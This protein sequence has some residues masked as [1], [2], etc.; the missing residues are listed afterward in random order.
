MQL[1]NQLKTPSF[2]Q[3]L[4][5][6]I[7][8]IEFLQ[9]ASKQYP[10][11]FSSS[12]LLGQT[13]VFI[14]HPQ[15]L[16]DFFTNDRK[17]FVLPPTK[18]VQPIVGES[19]L[20]TLVG[21][22]HKRQR[23]FLMPP[24]HGE[25]MHSYGEIICN[26]TK[27]I[28]SQ[29]PLNQP[30]SAQTVTLKIALELIL[31]VVFGLHEGEKYQ[32]LQHL[33]ELMFDF[34]QSPL[35]SSF[36]YLPFL[37]RNLGPWS[38]WVKFVRLKQ[39]IDNL[40][41]T[42]IA[43]RRAQQNSDRVDI[44]SLLLEAKD[45]EGQSLTDQELLNELMTLL[46]AGH[47]TTGIA[48]A[49]GLYWTHHK[50]EVGERLRKELDSLGTSKDP[51]SIFRLPY[52]T[53]VCNETLRIYPVSAVTF[54]RV[55]KEPIELLK[56]RLEPGTIVIGGIYLTHHRED[57]YPNPQQFLPERFLERQYSPYEFLPFGGGMR[58]CLGEALAIFEIK[59]ILA[60]I[61]SHYQLKLIDERPEKPLLRGFN[62]APA[63]GVQMMI[64]QERVY[65]GTKQAL[66]KIL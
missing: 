10:D 38:P 44:L 22:H 37:R 35:Y 45:E 13:S 55:V 29:L 23:Q 57:L 7:D 50:P 14:H 20:L 33:L 64:T 3:T 18:V 49:W 5:F 26:L 9:K 6:I 1:P 31:Q 65:Q 62:I 4:Q 48:M 41:Y 47:E 19:S 25:R 43:K 66:A 27:K 16:Q 58:R 28:F 32:K 46:F 34:F 54:P 59:L 11:I 53:A 12:F 30:F 63:H 36:L 60:T 40:L 17:K 51:M 2:L 15:A 52:L 24:F 8:P 42:E 61:L 39:Q 56:H 21:E